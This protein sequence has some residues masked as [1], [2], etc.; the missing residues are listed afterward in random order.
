[1]RGKD[2]N[3]EIAGS[4]GKES[5]VRMPIHVQNGR[6]VLLDVLSHPPIVI[7]LKVAN[8]DAFCSAANSKLVL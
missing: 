4:G 2:S 1:V 5:V 7:L 8:R 6:L 3:L